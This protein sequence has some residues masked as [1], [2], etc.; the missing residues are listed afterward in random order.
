MSVSEPLDSIFTSSGRRRKMGVVPFFTSLAGTVVVVLMIAVIIGV[1]VAFFLSSRTTG[2]IRTL[3]EWATALS[4]A[5]FVAIVLAWHPWQGPYPALFA[6]TVLGFVVAVSYL[7]LAVM[8][9]LRT[10]ESRWTVLVTCR[11]YDLPV[12]RTFTTLFN[13]TKPEL[14]N[15]LGLFVARLIS[16]SAAL[17]LFLFGRQYAWIAVFLLGVSAIT[18]DKSTQI[19]RDYKTPSLS[20]VIRTITRTASAFTDGASRPIGR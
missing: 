15:A 20:P 6:P 18:Q 17:T 1:A 19:C 16:D 2:I 11:A 7:P 4:G 10:L 8:L 3:T 13:S 14:I 9:L 12:T 5:G